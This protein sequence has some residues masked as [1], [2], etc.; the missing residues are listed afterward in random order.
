MNTF[1]LFSLSGTCAH[2]LAI[3]IQLEDWLVQGYSDIPDDI[4][5]TSTA[6]QWQ[7]PRGAKI[8]PVPIAGMVFSK[9]TTVIRKRRPVKPSYYDNRY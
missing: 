9:P 7:K 1:D 4:S 6:Q 5:S 3:I 8:E 2:V